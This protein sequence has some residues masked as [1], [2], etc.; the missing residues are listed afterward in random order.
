M[1]KTVWI[2]G[3]SGLIGQHLVEQ[4]A[5]DDDYSRIIALVRKPLD[6]AAFNHPKVEQFKV[7][8]DQLQAPSEQ[9]DSLFCALGSTTRKSPNY[10]DYFR[11]DVTYPLEFAKLGLKHGASYYGLVSAHGAKASS[12][13]SYLKMKGTLEDAL[14]ALNY[15]R[16]AIARPSLLKGDRAEF[17]I[18]EKASEGLMSLLPGNYRAIDAKHVAQ[19]LIQADK[20]QA[21]G[22]RVLQ[23]KEM[24]SP[25]YIPF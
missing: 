6:R 21:Q 19:S 10:D 4:L 18:L 13:S 12:F 2:A 20:R 14:T 9:V 24:Q 3:A 7:D 17:R 25:E 8:F 15:S 16:L 22:K 5:A 23:S 1:S 11:I